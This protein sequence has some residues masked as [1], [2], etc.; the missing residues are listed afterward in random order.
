MAALFLAM[1]LWVFL[2]PEPKKEE[3]DADTMVAAADAAIAAARGS[4][5]GTMVRQIGG[6][7]MFGMIVEPNSDPDGWR[8]EAKA[9]CIGQS[10]CKVF[11]WTDAAEAATALPMTD[12]E[13]EKQAFSYGINRNT[14]YDQALWDCD[15]FPRSNKSECM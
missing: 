6:D 11:V 13:V 1:I 9:Q 2:A 10:V 4:V 5:S 3:P 8:A 7:G 14:G 12:R 15:R